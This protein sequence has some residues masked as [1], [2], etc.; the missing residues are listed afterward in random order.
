MFIIYFLSLSITYDLQIF[1]VEIEV[2]VFFYFKC[3]QIFFKTLTLKGI[4]CLTDK[5]QKGQV[6]VAV[7]IL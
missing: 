2:K 7:K 5:L 3:R 6:L 4:I 1:E